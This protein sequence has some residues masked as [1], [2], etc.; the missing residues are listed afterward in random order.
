METRDRAI[1]RIRAHLPSG[2]DPGCDLREDTVLSDLGVTSLHLIT[3]LTSIQ[4]EYHLSSDVVMSGGFP[5][6]V[7]DIL[8]IIERG[9]PPA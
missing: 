7:G 6:T 9:A 4:R 2:N 3:L 8:E 1:S 5:R